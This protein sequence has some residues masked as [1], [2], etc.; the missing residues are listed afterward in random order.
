MG[1]YE[2]GCMNNEIVSWHDKQY[3]ANIYISPIHELNLI[4]LVIKTNPHGS[5]WIDH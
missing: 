1:Y 2:I 4:R 5:I 3:V